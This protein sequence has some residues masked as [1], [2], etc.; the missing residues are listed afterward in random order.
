MLAL[1]RFVI[2]T[3]RSVFFLLMVGDHLLD[4]S[5]V[6]VVPSSRIYAYHR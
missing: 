6:N 4:L 5:I 2:C 1:R 3:S